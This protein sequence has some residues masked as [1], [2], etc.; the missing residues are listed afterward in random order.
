MLNEHALNTS[1][2]NSA[3]SRISWHRARRRPEESAL[4]RIVYNYH[5]EL[6]YVWEDRFQSEYGVYRDVVREAFLD[7]LDCGIQTAVQSLAEICA[8]DQ[9][10]TRLSIL[11]VIVNRGLFEVPDV[12]KLIMKSDECLEE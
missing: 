9:N 12:F 7:Y 3:K 2:W 1:R 10:P 5:E 11:K 8:D 6:S 4:Y